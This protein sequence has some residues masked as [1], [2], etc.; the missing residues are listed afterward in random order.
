[1][2]VIY[3]RYDSCVSYIGDITHVTLQHTYTYVYA[4]TCSIY[5]YIYTHTHTHKHWPPHSCSAQHG[6]SPQNPITCRTSSPNIHI[7]VCI[8]IH[9]I[10]I[11]ICI[12]THLTNMYKHIT[13]M[14][15]PAYTHTYI[16]IHTHA[17]SGPTLPPYTCTASLQHPITL[18]YTYMHMH[19]YT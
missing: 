17:H 19:T 2:Y 3:K 10:H 11:C 5:I 1:M 8:H 9:I 4:S 16:Y 13:C 18:Q 6:V 14:R 12:H 15:H 7:C